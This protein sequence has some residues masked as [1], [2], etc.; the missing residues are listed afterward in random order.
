M[1]ARPDDWASYANLGNF[2]ME[3][4][5][6]P[7]AAASFETATKLE[8][9]QTRP[10]GQCLDGLQQHVAERQGRSRACAGR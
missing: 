3:R 7:A 6:F 8:P 1:Q 4:R 2:Y 10:A 9:R 5:D